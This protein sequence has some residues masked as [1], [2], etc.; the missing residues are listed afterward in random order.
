MPLFPRPSRHRRTI[1]ALV[2]VG[3]AGAF[4][5]ARFGG[6]GTPPAAPVAAAVASAQSGEPSRPVATATGTR[7]T[8]LPPTL[9]PTPADT[10]ARDVDY[11]ALLRRDLDSD[12]EGTRIAAVEAAVS[13]TAVDALP[14]LERFLLRGDPE[15]APS[16]IHAV[17]QLGAAAEASKRDA[18]AATL[19]GWLRDELK[20][21]GADVAGNV[22]NLVE[23]LGDVGGRGAVDALAGTLDRGE[24]PL[25]VETLAVI[26]LGELGDGLARRS[27]ERFAT[28]VA[29]LPPAEGLDGELRA[30]ALDAAR[31]TLSRI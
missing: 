19:A 31:S 17:A 15:V 16:V 18:A 14:E 20:R 28:R 24:L 4:C 10:R 26:K 9:A 1:V 2:A 13:A 8:D 5:V 7:P 30:E 12:D 22:S 23:A 3:C 29:A 21:E 11:A 27:V 6:H 25:H